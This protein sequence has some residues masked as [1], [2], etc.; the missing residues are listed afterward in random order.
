MTVAFIH[1]DGTDELIRD[2]GADAVA[3]G[4]DELVRDVQAA[5]EKHGVTFLGTDADKDGG[6]IILVAGAPSAVGEDEE[7][8]LLAVRAIID[9]ETTIPVR[10]GVNKG[11]VFS[12]EIGPPYRRT[13]TVMGDAVNLAAR[14][15]SK[16]EPGQVLA[17]GGVLEASSL[18][19]Q[20]D[21]AR[22]VHGEGEEG[23]GSCV[24]RGGSGRCQVER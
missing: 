22:A 15:M 3:Y 7:R 13:Y 16:A 21:R 6:K 5:C 2:A 8:M 23:T 18:A 9:A 10:I 14:V 20:R 17:T 24:R 12:G 1:Y 19:L 11:P 4:L